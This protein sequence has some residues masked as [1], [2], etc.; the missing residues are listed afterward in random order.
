MPPREEMPQLE[1]CMLNSQLNEKLVT[2]EPG[3][4]KNFFSNWCSLTSDPEILETISCLPIDVSS[5]PERG[6]QHYCSTQQ[7]SINDHEIKKPL[8]KKVV[9]RSKHED[10]EIIYPIF[11]REKPDGS[12]RLVLNPFRHD[13]RRTEKI[14]LNFYFHTT[15]WCLKRP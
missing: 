6:H 12:F 3:K 2:F 15:W 9:A 1:V 13:P 14:N 7:Q 11:L 5:S 10:V 8:T 4:A